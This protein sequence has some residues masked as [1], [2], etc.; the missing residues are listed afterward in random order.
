MAMAVFSV[1]RLGAFRYIR[2]ASQKKKKKKK[3]QQT[4]LKQNKQKSQL[5]ALDLTLSF[6]LVSGIS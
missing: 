4:N 5:D 6:L 3:T 1:D 2:L